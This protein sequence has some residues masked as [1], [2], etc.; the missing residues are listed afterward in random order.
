MILRDDKNYP[1]IKVTIKDDWP[2]LVDRTDYQAMVDE[3]LLIP[4]G[5]E[6]S[7]NKITH[8]KEQ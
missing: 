6:P 5:K 7:R 1:L 3:V 4:E 8:L 2:R